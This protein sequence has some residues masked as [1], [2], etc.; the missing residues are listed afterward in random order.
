MFALKIISGPALIGT[1]F[2]L[3]LIIIGEQRI[4]GDMD[5]KWH[6]VINPV[7]GGGQSLGLWPQI[8]AALD[9]QGHQYTLHRTEAPRHAIEIVRQCV[10]NGATRVLSIGGDGTHHEVVNGLMSASSRKP[11]LTLGVIPVGTGNDWVRT[12]GIPRKLT[13][14]LATLEQARTVSHSVGKITFLGSGLDHERYFMNVAGFGLDA[15]I[16]Q[17][18]KRSTLVRWGSLAYFFAGIRGVLT[19]NPQSANIQWP[20]GAHRGS[21][22]TIHAGISK[23]SGGGMTFTPH[24]R[25]SGDQLALTTISSKSRLSLLLNMGR[26]YTGSIGRFGGT[27]MWNA[28]SV[29]IAQEQG[30]S[31]AV[32]ADGEFLG[33]CPVKVE[34]IPNAF[35]VVVG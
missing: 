11:D 15:A 29:E 1:L 16:I 27:T 31:I 8:S 4:S 33:Y 9:R 5:V 10:E 3:P 35:N 23:F 26:A 12:L 28:R 18:L 14:A 13:Q 7:A 2:Y 24:A 20:G 19:Y 32:E 17:H 22:F 21:Y 6:A 25:I 30:E 34:C